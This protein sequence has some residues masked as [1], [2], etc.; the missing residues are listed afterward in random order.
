MSSVLASAAGYFHRF[1]NH[2][3]SPKELRTFMSE[4][5]LRVDAHS[6]SLIQL[7]TIIDADERRIR[8]NQLK[9]ETESLLNECRRW[10]NAAVGIAKDR[11]SKRGVKESELLLEVNSHPPAYRHAAAVIDFIDR[12]GSGSAP[13]VTVAGLDEII[14]L[15]HCPLLCT[16]D[17]QKYVF[18]FCLPAHQLRAANLGLR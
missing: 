4:A 1:S 17:S 3:N 18:H 14:H 10:L 9:S 8:A 15:V 5:K 11:T 13:T 6:W 2:S 16:T 7:P 12:L